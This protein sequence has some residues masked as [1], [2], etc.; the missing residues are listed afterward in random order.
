M[1]IRSLAAILIVASAFIIVTGQTPDPKKKN[2]ADK[3]ATTPS[4]NRS[5]M[6]RDM[7]FPNG[8]NL[9]FL[10]KE[11]ARDIDLNVLFD[12]ESN[13]NFRIVKIELR[14]V[15]IPAALN[16]ILVQEGLVSEEV[17]PKTILVASRLRGTSIPKIGVGVT[18]LPE[19]LAKYFKVEGGILIN[20]VKAD[21][22]GSKAGLKAGDVIVG[23][24]GESVRGALGL[25][26]AIDE[27]RSSDFTLRIVRNHKN[28][29]VNIH[30]ANPSP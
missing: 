10:I 21:L 9:E 27:K 11:L 20:E 17:G 6:L 1:L 3:V 2:V 14:G 18:P 13:L 22:P 4:G 29:T 28:R 25:I 16:Y 5:E 24:D 12:R 23:I 7:P 15:T 30:L 19:Q 8:V 26:H